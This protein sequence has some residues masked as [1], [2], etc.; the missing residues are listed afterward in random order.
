[1]SDPIIELNVALIA[2]ASASV[3][4]FIA[5][6][7]SLTGLF[8]SK[9][10][11]TSKFRQAWIDE[12]RKDIALLVAHAHQIFSYAKLAIEPDH[13]KFW[14]STREDY[15]ELNK[16][17]MRIKLRLNPTECES[18]MILQSLSEMEALFKETK[19]S[20]EN[21]DVELQKIF[22]IVAALERD[23]P[24]LLK[25]EWSRVK[26]GEKIYRAAKWVALALFISTLISS[27]YLIM[28]LRY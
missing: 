16:A 6:T 4:A 19:L 18:R 9:E 21:V 25:K 8:M 27:I 11:D 10:Q 2:A 22:R 17:S 28:R 14:R 13:E 15:L 1:M 23:A 20:P 24:P 7:F 3:A 5:G 26:S 12:L